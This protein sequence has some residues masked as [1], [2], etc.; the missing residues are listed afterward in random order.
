[1][2]LSPY[3]RAGLTLLLTLAT[4]VACRAADDAASTAPEQGKIDLNQPYHC[5]FTETPVVIDGVLD[6]PV[7]Q[8]A[9][10]V[11]MATYGKRERPLSLTEAR[12]A[13]DRDYLY[14]AFKAY[15]EDIWSYLTER[16][17]STASE[18]VLEVFFKT[19]PE[20]PA[21]FNFE[22]NALGTVYDAYHVRRAGTPERPQ[23][24]FYKRWMRWDCEGLRMAINIHGTLNDPTDRD[25]YW[26]MEVAI[27]FRKAAN[28]PPVR[29]LPA[30]VFTTTK[31]GAA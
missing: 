20:R 10:L 25:E 16:D 8:K 30:V 11:S 28:S 19:H 14:V 26:I 6:D 17:S 9:P 12:M 24:F 4:A 29:P 27:P 13:Y 2:T 7:W 1:M 31:S 15:D 18:D 22:I 5:M 21:Y 23:S 3:W